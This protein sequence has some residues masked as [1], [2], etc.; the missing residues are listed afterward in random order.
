[1]L[2]VIDGS[3][4]LRKAIRDVFGERAAVQHLREHT[5]LGGRTRC[6]SLPTEVSSSTPP[7]RAPSALFPLSFI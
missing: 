6:R 5:E 2:F 7:T 4:A 3:K 1:M